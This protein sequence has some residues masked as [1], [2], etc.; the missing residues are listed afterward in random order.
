MLYGEIQTTLISSLKE[1]KR[2]RKREG[3]EEEEEAKSR[4]LFTL[5]FV[6]ADLIAPRAT[7]SN[8]NLHIKR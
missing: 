2:K 8:D 5:I 4:T 6:S 1:K 7:G 3:E